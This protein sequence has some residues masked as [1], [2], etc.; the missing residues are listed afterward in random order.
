MGSIAIL[1]IAKCIGR[2][3]LFEFF[4]KESLPFYAFQNKLVIPVG[5]KISCSILTA[6]G[7]GKISWVVTLIFSLIGL[8]IV[9]MIIDKKVPWL[10][11][12]K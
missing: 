11:G 1:Q 6:L 8:S 2:N 7:L 4:S 5:N 9:S 3:R 12:K 10:V